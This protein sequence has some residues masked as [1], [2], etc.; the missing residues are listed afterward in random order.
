MAGLFLKPRC[1]AAAPAM[2]NSD[3]PIIPLSLLKKNGKVDA[4]IHDRRANA[5]TPWHRWGGLASSFAT[6]ESGGKCSVIVSSPPHRQT[7]M[8]LGGELM[9]R[10]GSSFGDVSKRKRESRITSTMIA[11]FIAQIAPM[12]IRGPAPRDSY[13]GSCRSGHGFLDGGARA[14]SSRAGSLGLVLEIAFERLWLT[15]ST[16]KT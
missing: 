3:D 12:Q 11:S 10:P 7:D 4:S 9:H 13:S 14:G 16:S 2:V 8:R 5:S 6:H 15:M 1:W